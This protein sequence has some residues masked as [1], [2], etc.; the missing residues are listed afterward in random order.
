MPAPPE[1]SEPAMVSRRNKLRG[2]GDRHP[3]ARPPDAEDEEED[4]DADRL[5]EGEAAQ[6]A[7]VLGA[8]ELDGEALG[9]QEGEDGEDDRARRPAPPQI[10]HAERPDAQAD[11]RLVDLG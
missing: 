8:Q 6:E 10:A 4:R 5:G 1:E 11:Q 2:A 7:V 3:A 9:G